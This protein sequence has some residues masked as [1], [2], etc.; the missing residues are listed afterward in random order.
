MLVHAAHGDVALAAP[1]GLQLNLSG[2]GWVEFG[3]VMH[4]SD[5]LVSRYNYNDNF[6]ERPGAQF[7]ILA[8]MGDHWDGAMGLGGYQSQDPQGGIYNSTQRKSE[9]GFNVYITQAKFAYTLGETLGEKEAPPLKVTF[10]LFPFVYN[11]N[12][13]NL[14]EYLLR[15]PVY[16]GIV[17]SNFESRQIDPSIANTLGINIKSTLHG[18]TQDLILK[19]ETD[20]PPLFDFSLAYL[21]QYEVKGLFTI[22]FGVNF[23]RLLPM[24]PELTNL[25]DPGFKKDN[26]SVLSAHSP[27]QQKYIYVLSDTVAF[28]ADGTL[29]PNAAHHDS[30]NG[31]FTKLDDTTAIWS[32]RDTTTFTHKGTKVM[33]RFSFDPKFL[34]YGA[35]HGPFGAND[36]KIYGE[37]AIIG[38]RNYPGVYTDIMQRIPVMMGFNIPTFGLLDDCALEVEWYG[39][40]F[41][42]D[43]FKLVKETSPIPVSNHTQEYDRKPDAQG[44][45][46]SDSTIAFADVDVEHMTKDDWKW[47]LYMSKTVQKYVKVSFQVANDH[48][49]P[50]ENSASG[51]TTRYESA[52]T[53][54]RDYYAM[55]KIGFTF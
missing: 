47:S 45:L 32:S 12:V 5:T 42:D 20:L 53:E 30:T 3:R 31:T 8:Q 22:G 27:Y 4:S 55:M 24:K 38:T 41:R 44:R 40:K 25:T 13:R 23:S 48:Y 43:Y 52:F 33:G 37:A 26:R 9:T 6:I 10:G 1:E 29:K 15:G 50:W 39:A 18:F 7:T 49:R 51:N 19:S 21:A 16:P 17:M 34:F 28:N 54:L 11:P 46:E 14:G 2:K 35:G 36:L